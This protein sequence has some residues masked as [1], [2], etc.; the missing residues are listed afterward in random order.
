MTYNK[1]ERITSEIITFVINLPE[2]KDRRLNS[3]NRVRTVGLEPEFVPATSGKDVKLRGING[4][5][6]AN[7]IALWIS[8]RNTW[9]SFLRSESKFCFI[10]ED[11][12]LFTPESKKIIANIKRLEN[13]SFDILQI[14]FLP[15]GNRWNLDLHELILRIRLKIYRLV[16]R[17][18]KN[19][20]SLRFIYKFIGQ[21]PNNFQNKILSRYSDINEMTKIELQLGNNLKLFPNFRSGTHAYLLSRSGAIKLL[22]YNI[23]TILGSDLALQML[24]MTKALKIYRLSRPLALQDNTPVSLGEPHLIESDLG[25]YILG[26]DGL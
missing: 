14:G 17:F 23:P 18:L 9:E 12:V 19:S 25:K 1:N 26:G 7:V 22:N 3:S 24:A 5:A 10:F 15:L 20:F 6:P 13:C 8:H 11:D 2:R 16:I 4:Y 21:I